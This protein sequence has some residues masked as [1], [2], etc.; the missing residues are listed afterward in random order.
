[1]SKSNEKK[2][3]QLGMP[4]GTASGKLRKQIMFSLIQVCGMDDCHQCGY[5]IESVETLSIDH[6]V[7]W[8]DSG[9]PVG[10][11]FN[12]DNIAFSHINCN[13]RAGRR[14]IKP[15]PSLAA[16]RRGCRCPECRELSSL[17]CKA[18]YQLS[19]QK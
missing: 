8:L 16:Y 9:D 18:R 10:L 15:C 19:L 5:K 17:D 13:I 6:K 11:F 1:M 3:K 7:P 12:L 4:H 2:S 14:T